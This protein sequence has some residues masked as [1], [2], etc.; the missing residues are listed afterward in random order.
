M[1][2]RPNIAGVLTG[3]AEPGVKTVLPGKAIEMDFRLVP[4]Q[5]PDDIFA[6]VAGPSQGPRL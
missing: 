1:N 3:Y 4:N 5:D 6:K 2:R